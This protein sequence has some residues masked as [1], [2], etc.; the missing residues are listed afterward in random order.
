MSWRFQ[1]CLAIV[2]ACSGPSTTAQWPLE[3]ALLCAMVLIAEQIES[4]MPCG[5]LATWLV[6]LCGGSA[7]ITNT[8]ESSALKPF[9]TW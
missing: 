5:S 7:A 1:P 2:V 4:R 9:S 8:V 3:T 6:T